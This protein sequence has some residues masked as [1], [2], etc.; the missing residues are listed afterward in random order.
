MVHLRHCRMLAAG[1]ALCAGVLFSAAPAR[2]QARA[3]GLEKEKKRVLEQLNAALHGPAAERNAAL[4]EL[5]QLER[6]QVREHKV[7]DFVLKFIKNDTQ[8][9]RLRRTAID[10]AV[11]LATDVDTALKERALRELLRFLDSARENLLVRRAVAARIHAL[12]NRKSLG[13]HRR[14][15]RVLERIAVGTEPTF[16]RVAAVVSVGRIGWLGSFSVIRKALAH[17]EVE[18]KDAGFEALDAWLNVNPDGPP[19]VTSRNCPRCSFSC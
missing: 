19:A 9:P 13:E 5:G 14:A 16:L 1:A 8:S 12:V 11:K 7:F 2:G 6:D 18:I 3:G 10:T 17:R 4:V 15:I